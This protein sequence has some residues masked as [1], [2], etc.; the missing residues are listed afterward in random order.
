[1]NWSKSLL[2]ASAAALA[3]TAFAAEAQDKPKRMGYVTN[4]ATHEW[5]QNVIKGMQDR[6]KELGLRWKMLTSN[7]LVF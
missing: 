6:A 3:L 5:Y 4:Y 2:F 1:M 7:A